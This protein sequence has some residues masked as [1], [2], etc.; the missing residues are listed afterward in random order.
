MSSTNRDDSLPFPRDLIEAYAA[1]ELEDPTLVGQIESNTELMREVV[2]IQEENDFLTKLAGAWS[3]MPGATKSGPPRQQIEGYRIINEVF[4]G[5]QGVVYKGLQENTKRIVAIKVMLGGA[6]AS[7]RARQRFER[8]VELIASLRHENIVTVYDSGSLPDGSSFF[9]M[10]FIKGVPLSRAHIFGRDTLPDDHEDSF[11]IRIQQFISICHAIQY[12]HQRGIIH[13][14]LK[15]GN[16]MVDRTGTPKVFDFGVA[17]VIGPSSGTEATLTG[18]FVGTFAYASPEQVKGDADAVDTRSDVYALGLI[19]YELLTEEHPYPVRGSVA[20]IIKNIT[21]TEAAPLTR[22]EPGIKRDLQAIVLKS[23]EK[24]PDHRYQSA[25]AFAQDLQNYLDGEPVEAMRDNASYV[26]G[27]VMRRYRLPL[28]V[29]T[30]VVLAL[31]LVSISMSILWYRAVKAE[32][33]AGERLVAVERESR[34]RGEVTDMYTD[35]IESLQPEH[36]LGTELT[37]REMIDQAARIADQRS[38]VEPEVQSALLEAIGNTY[39]A[40]DKL[41]EARSHLENSLQLRIDAIGVDSLPV[42]ESR[43]DL[44]YLYLVLGEIEE[45]R[46]SF[47]ACLAIWDGPG[48]LSDRAATLHALGRVAESEGKIDEAM[49]QANES[50]QLRMKD[51]NPDLIDITELKITMARL[52]RKRKE[53][54]EAEKL[55]REALAD[56]RDNGQAVSPMSATILTNLAVVMW[57]RDRLEEAESLHR[58]SLAQRRRFY[59]EGHS[60]IGKSLLGLGSVL[61]K[62]DKNLDAEPHLREAIEVFQSR[63]GPNHSVVANA[64]NVYG[65]VLFKLGQYEAARDTYQRSLSICRRSY[66]PESWQAAE[67]EVGLALALSRLGQHQ[68]AEVLLINGHRLL[69]DKYG[70]G[71]RQTFRAM[72]GLRDLYEAT[73]DTT[74]MTLWSQRIEQAQDGK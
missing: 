43:Y 4:R 19:L 36:G 45:A 38:V 66:G 44:G 25:A 70:S 29:G 34:M 47:E 73:G 20:D 23:L 32:R 51:T 22:H 8:E 10:E 67:Q 46:S 28:M 35:I 14:D 55:Y 63:F 7:E 15:P 17:K 3:T 59:P 71:H 26:L 1:G 37:V 57:Q 74:Q 33:I 39:L 2:R 52:H 16:I 60:E 5:G 31:V 30:G 72:N 56:L 27:K 69:A 54:D 21:S 12:A 53:S 68:E 13:R 18:E 6:L 61:H 50:L 41:P 42:A 62:M 49:A 65:Q 9:V 48:D 24:D 11:R 64:S 58:E 40:L